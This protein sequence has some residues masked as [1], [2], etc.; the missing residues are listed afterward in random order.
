[1]IIYDYLSCRNKS[2]VGPTPGLGSLP[3]GYAPKP[4]D[5]QLHSDKTNPLY[6]LIRKLKNTGVM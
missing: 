1:M 3:I 6:S 4:A 2:F 5:M